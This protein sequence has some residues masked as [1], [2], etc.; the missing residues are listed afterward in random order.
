M[1]NAAS[2]GRLAGDGA[3]GQDA[4]AGS[5]RVRS[6]RTPEAVAVSAARRRAVMLAG[7][8]GVVVAVVLIGILVVPAGIAV[9]VAVGV[10]VGVAVAVGL[11]R[12][13]P[14]TL[15]RALGARPAEESRW[16][17]PFGLLDGLCATMGLPVPALWVLDDPCANALV[18][19]TT[20][21]STTLVVTTG[22][23]VQL[24]PVQLEGVLAHELS[25]IKLGDVAVGTVSAVLWLPLARFGDA[26]AVVH[27]LRGKG[28][29]LRTDLY[30]VGVTR[31][32]PG[33]RSALEQMTAA[34]GATSSGSVHGSHLA[35]TR[36]G[37]VTRWLWTVSL[38]DP[39]VGDAIVGNLDVAQ[40]RIEALDE[41]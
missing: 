13:A 20:P 12:R 22:L 37:R 9:A 16:P 26:G 41:L 36:V 4:V 23:L 29:D 38:G 1:A 15:V 17:R 14:T 39:P 27:R 35:G 31:Y 5:A 21:T 34:G 3:A 30:A 8:P 19:G 2:S 32:P 33:L 40:V 28:R 25:H 18:V 24:D 6:T 10:V 7:A 11:W